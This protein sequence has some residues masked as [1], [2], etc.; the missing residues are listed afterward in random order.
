M[1][2][3][4]AVGGFALS[5]APRGALGPP[6]V[7]AA[8]AAG[9]FAWVLRSPLDERR[10]DL[11][12]ALAVLISSLGLAVVARLSSELAQRQELWLGLSLVLAIAA[13]LAFDRFRRLAAYKYVWVL[14]SIVL[15]VL[16]ALFGQEVN[17]AK[18]WIRVGPV[19]Y[20]P[21]ELIKLFI[22]LFMAAYLAE[23]ADVI[24][25]AKPWSFR[26]NAKYLGPLFLGWG[27]SMAIL[28]FER[29]IGMATLLLATFA[30]MLYVATRRVDLIAGGFGLFALAVWWAVR[31]YSYVD[32]RFAVWR[33]PFADPLGRGYQALQGL[34]S[35]AAGG[36]FGTGYGLGH[37]DY[38]P[39]VSTDYVYAALSEE[40][41]AL[42]GFVL[43]AA[44]LVLLIRAFGV[45]QSQPDL[46][47]KLLAT[48]LAATLGFQVAIIVG[49]V[50]GLFPLTGITLPFVSYGG[51]SLV[52]NFL[53]VA[54]IWAVGSDRRRA[55]VEPAAAQAA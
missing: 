35:L 28:V 33:D 10:D 50:L 23:T 2:A 52:A 11:L 55:K 39:A 16:V 4:L 34:F 40:F 54:L 7:L 19:Q 49:G 43:V 53:L 36:L 15:F 27:A 31:H 5:L 14:G 6:W 30:A 9:A 18:L 32:A 38:I 24:A 47:A 8:L 26:A 17:G 22:V 3:A 51:S 21:I 45:A 46:Y 20:E 37:P 41:G 13:S 48:G 29:D 42:G 1:A 25:A 12:P 44:F